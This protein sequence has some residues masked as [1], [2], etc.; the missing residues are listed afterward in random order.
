RPLEDIFGRRGGTLLEFRW[1]ASAAKQALGQVK[2]PTLIFHPRDDDQSHIRNTF[3]LQKRL[4]GL[5]EVIVLEDSYHMATLDRQR[6]VV[7]EKTIAFTDWVAQRHQGGQ[8]IER[9]RQGLA[10]GLE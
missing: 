10:A 1:L 8:E 9:T 3:L 7:V 6:T 5:T 4:G 2:Q